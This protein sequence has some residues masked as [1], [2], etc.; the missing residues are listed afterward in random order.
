MAECRVMGKRIGMSR[1]GTWPKS[2]SLSE[3]WHL[4]IMD[5]ISQEMRTG[6]CVT[7]KGSKS[8]E[9]LNYGVVFDDMLCAVKPTGQLM[10]QSIISTHV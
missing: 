7:G 2:A 10:L 3:L 1:T 6:E 9:E 8:V 4:G 5:H